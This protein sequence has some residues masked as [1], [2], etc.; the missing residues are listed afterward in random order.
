M[1]EQYLLRFRLP[2]Y[3]QVSDQFLGVR[4]VVKVWA[5]LNSNEKLEL[6]LTPPVMSTVLPLADIEDLS[7]EIAG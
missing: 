3:D 7:G 4:A 5:T 6:L 1:R 2:D